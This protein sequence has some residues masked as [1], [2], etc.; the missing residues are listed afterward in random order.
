[1]VRVGRSSLIRGYFIVFPTVLHS[2]VNCPFFQKT[3]VSFSQQHMEPFYKV[4][5]QKCSIGLTKRRR[6]GG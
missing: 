3:E 1:M 6:G 2:F 5:F 4:L